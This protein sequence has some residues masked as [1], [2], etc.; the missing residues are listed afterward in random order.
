LLL[1]K[2]NTQSGLQDDLRKEKEAAQQRD[3]AIRQLTTEN[4]ELHKKHAQLSLRNPED[5][6]R[7]Y[8]P[9]PRF[10]LLSP[11]LL[12]NAPFIAILL[13]WQ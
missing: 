12:F 4:E 5:F 3:T 1:S 7:E 8:S 6:Y 11:S 13:P 2:T 10:P 9:L